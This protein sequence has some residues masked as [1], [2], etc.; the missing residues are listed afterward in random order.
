[1]CNEYLLHLSR[2]IHLNPVQAGLV[3]HPENWVYSSYKDYLGLHKSPWLHPDIVLYQ[4]N[5]PED[6]RVFVEDY[7]PK[8]R[9]SIAHLLFDT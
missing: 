4:F 3:Q 9:E 2:Y 8:D 7:Q 6:Y 5:S 1:V